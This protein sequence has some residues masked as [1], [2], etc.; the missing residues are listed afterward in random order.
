M[1]GPSCYAAIAVL[2]C[3]STAITTGRL[4]KMKLGANRNKIMNGDV[5]GEPEVI[6]Q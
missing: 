5:V 4:L 1:I 2:F 6:G 3:R